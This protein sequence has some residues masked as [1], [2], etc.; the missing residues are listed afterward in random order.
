LAFGALTLTVSAV[1][2]VVPPVGGKLTAIE[3]AR[4]FSFLSSVVALPVA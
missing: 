4:A 2:L 1:F 3:S